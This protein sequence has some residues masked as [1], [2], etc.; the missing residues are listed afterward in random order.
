MNAYLKK[1]QLT[2]QSIKKMEAPQSVAASGQKEHLVWLDV[3]RFVAMFTLVCC[4]CANPFNWT[5]EDSP[6]ILNVKFWGAIYGSM[7]RHSVPLFVM[8]TGALLLPIRSDALPFYKKRIGRV[9][10]PFLIWSAAYCLFPV[11]V[12]LLGGG[13]E[14]IL[15]FFPYAESICFR[16]SSAVPLPSSLNSNT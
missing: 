3:V 13:R 10:F 5:P 15:S 11:A 9:F 1:K 2:L 14:L 4:H 12:R 6:I 8:I 16:A 7:L